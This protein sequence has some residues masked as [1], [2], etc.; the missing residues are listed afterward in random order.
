MHSL[1]PVY[2]L[3]NY[4]N[5]IKEAPVKRILT[6]LRRGHH[7][8]NEC[9]GRYNGIDKSMRICKLCGS[10]EVEDLDHFLLKMFTL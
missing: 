2:K 8:L 9:T 10:D 1:K 6:M 3:S 7:C 4:I 5:V